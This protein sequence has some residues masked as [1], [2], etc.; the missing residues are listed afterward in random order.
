MLT[1]DGGRAL[2]Y[3]PPYAPLR[4]WIAGMMRQ[5]GVECTAD[6][7]FITNG[8]QQGLT[9]LSRLLLDPGALAV[10]EE[11]TFTGIQQVTSGRGAEVI[12]IPVDLATGVDVEALEAAFSR[13]PRPRLAILIPDFHNPLGV[14]LTVEKRQRI[15][16]LAA[17]YQVPVIEDDPYSM[18]RFSGTPLPPIK[19]FDQLDQVFYLGS[20]SKILAP[21]LRLG[22]MIAPRA[23]LPRITAIRESIDLESSTLIQRAVHEFLSRGLLEP[24]LT[25]LNQVHCERRNALLEALQE[26]FGESATWTRPEGGLFVWATLAGDIDTWA[27]F[28]TAAAVEKVIYIPGAAF[29]VTGGHRSAMRLNFSALPAE[30]LRDAVQRLARVMHP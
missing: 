9:I 23:L 11:A 5:R 29:S 24:H 7:V 1:R 17:H 27:L 16:D 20:F 2:Q 6:E 21:T 19:A 3:S 26:E 18:L 14:S 8:N 13:T 30:A 12:G 28:E 15:A 25:H 22:W 10:V 4:G